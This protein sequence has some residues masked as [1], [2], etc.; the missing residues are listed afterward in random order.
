[1]PILRKEN[2]I[3]YFSHVPKCGG[4]AIEQYCKDIGIEI[5]FL[6]KRYY[7][8]L[9]K[10][11]WNNTSPQHI[12]NKS[13]DRLFPKQ[14]FSD[15]FTV[16]RH[17]IDRLKSAFIYQKYHE[18]SIEKNKSLSDFIDNDLQ[19]CSKKINIYDNHF[20][21]QHKIIANISN[22]KI[23]KLENGLNSVK[24]YLDKT[25]F[26]ETL[27]TEIKTLNKG[28]KLKNQ[29]EYY[30][31]EATKSKIFKIYKKDCDLFDYKL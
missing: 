19:V 5:A 15:Y 1:M 2:K 10:N 3:I 27:S 20:I 14:F 7:L 17:P 6:D 16:V 29:N 13:F 22:S 26:G 31:D 30:L 23:F 8:Q 9:S 21:E 12:D 28:K 11:V 24:E 25:F 18:K 4:T